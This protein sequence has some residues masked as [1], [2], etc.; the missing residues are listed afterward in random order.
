MRWIWRGGKP[1]SLG[2]AD[3]RGTAVASDGKR[4]AGQNVSGEAVVF[5]L[6]T[7]KA[8]P[9]GGIGSE[10]RVGEWTED[11]KA[12][13]VYSGTPWVTRV[14]RVEVLTGKR[15]PI[16]KVELNEKAGSTL[17]YLQYAERSKTSV[18]VTL[19]FLGSLYVV[20]GLE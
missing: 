8:Q 18:Y 12:L 6:G 9:V 14:D 11:G 4:I 1:E 3:F 13:L 17:L 20:E 5:D 15:T 19:R 7:Q 16:Q 10:G 2:P